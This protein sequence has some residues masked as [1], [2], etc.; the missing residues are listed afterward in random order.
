MDNK[1]LAQILNKCDVVATKT[2][3]P[4]KFSAYNRT[5]WT[6]IRHSVNLSIYQSPSKLFI[7]IKYYSSETIYKVKQYEQLSLF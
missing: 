3:N 5:E 1:T 2:D 6:P 7:K 4:E